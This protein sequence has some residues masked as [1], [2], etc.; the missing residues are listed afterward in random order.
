[1]QRGNG[2][3][4][5]FGSWEN[6]GGA[7]EAG[8]TLEEAVRREVTE[9]LGVVIGDIKK[10]LDYTPSFPEGEEVWHT[11]VF[12]SYILSGKPKIMEPHKCEAFGWF[13]K[14]QISKLPLTS[15]AKEDFERLGW[16]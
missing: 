1:M 5:Q 16:I 7:V 9:E 2:A 3:R 11:V 12:E 6:S 13:A 15:Y 14:D 4:T 10:I 8:E